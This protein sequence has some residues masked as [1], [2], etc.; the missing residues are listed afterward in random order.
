MPVIAA[1]LR[2]TRVT[3]PSPSFVR[4]RLQGRDLALLH[5]GGPAGLRDTRIKLVLGAGQP[6]P[7]GELTRDWYGQWRA[8]PVAERGVMRTYTIAA[9]HHDDAGLVHAVDIDVLLTDHAGPGVDWA[10]T[11]EP[12]S[13]VVL[14]GPGRPGPGE[15]PDPIGL[16]YR[17]G[18]AR[19]VVLVGDPTA[20]P[21][22][23]AIVASEAATGG[24]R[25]RVVASAPQEGDRI[26]VGARTDWVEVGALVDRAVD[27]CATTWLR[28]ERAQRI[29]CGEP[30]KGAAGARA[31]LP[32]V[33]IDAEVLWETPGGTIAA[34]GTGLSVS[35]PP[36]FWVA[37]E[38]GEVVAVRRAL[39]RDLGVP[40]EQVAFMGYWRRGRSESA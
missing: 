9:L 34:G 39:V 10:R 32:E 28:W 30:E 33:D 26:D 4:I 40:R 7:A 23:R 31:E 20:L 27:V 12:G 18:A 5:D 36:Y 29:R 17:P 8:L 38:A 37:G 19:E 3:R 21:A 14:I 2:V 6:L 13:A 16:E 11:A 25:V 35:R 15:E 22:I 24:R 1:P